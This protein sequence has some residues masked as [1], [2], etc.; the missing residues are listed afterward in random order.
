MKELTLK[1][2]IEYSYSPLN[3]ISLLCICRLLHFFSLHTMC[4]PFSCIVVPNVKVGLRHC[5]DKQ[6]NVICKWV[7]VSHVRD[8]VW[9]D[10]LTAD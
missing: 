9:K 10:I 3:K 8:K 7:N 5:F 6:E 1:T 2:F 4:V